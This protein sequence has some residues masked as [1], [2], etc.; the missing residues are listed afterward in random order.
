MYQL[1][2]MLCQYRLPAILALT[3][4]F[5]IG[6]SATPSR[7]ASKL[8]DF[9]QRDLAK[10]SIEHIPSTAVA[11]QP[12]QNNYALLLL[13]NAIRLQL[14]DENRLQTDDSIHSL[15]LQLKI[16]SYQDNVLLAQGKLYD[17]DEYLVYS[18]VKRRFAANDEWEVVMELVA[19]QMLDE[20]MSKM[21]ELQQS[22]I[23]EAPSRYFAYSSNYSN[24][25]IYNN[26][27]P[28]TPNTITY[29]NAP[30]YSDPYYNTWGGWRR[31]RE[32]HHSHDPHHEHQKNHRDEMHF[33]H[34]HPEKHQGAHWV[35]NGAIN[36][37]PGLVQI[38]NPRHGSKPDLNPVPITGKPATPASLPINGSEAVVN[39]LAEPGTGLVVNPIIGG[40]AITNPISDSSTENTTS[41]SVGTSFENN[42]TPTSDTTTGPA[43]AL[44]LDSN[45]STLTFAEP[46][47][48]IS[49]N[50]STGTIITDPSIA[51]SVD[52]S[53]SSNS[54]T[55]FDNDTIST[56][57]SSTSTDLG[58]ST[59][60]YPTTTPSVSIESS[61][62]GSSSS[63][64]DASPSY[65]SGSSVGSNNMDSNPGSSSSSSAP[66][67]A[68]TP[69]PPPPSPAPDPTPPPPPKS[70]PPASDTTATP[71]SP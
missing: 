5:I 65:N 44:N 8:A 58:I 67:P 16:L 39:T 7:G 63:A 51:P 53:I 20:L 42:L 21:H 18:Q 61:N 38:D 37:Q 62:N 45:S 11:S 3:L 10:I 43:T 1:A 70:T 46:N 15:R 71:P 2:Q 34:Q 69:P 13:E 41:P 56:P 50:P 9:R 54:G 28:R 4:L 14:A 52:T 57:N 48:G 27:R 25:N 12:I 59:S 64:I 30:V 60:G 35:N 29:S 47:P 49:P 36:N 19:E 55:S 17:D 32:N 24:Y 68:P 66:E 22:A 26:A 23:T 40:T 31:H 33:D 6:C